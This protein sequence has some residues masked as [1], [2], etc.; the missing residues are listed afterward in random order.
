MD[1]RKICAL[2]ARGQAGW[3]SS[4]PPMHVCHSSIL[5]QNLFPWYHKVYFHMPELQYDSYS[6]TF[7]HYTLGSLNP[8]FP[9]PISEFYTSEP[10]HL[11]Y[12]LSQSLPSKQRSTGVLVSTAR[13]MLKYFNVLLQFTFVM[14]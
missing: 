11:H 2:F 12:N 1:E 14:L 10:K 6:Y 9:I 7:K 4:T 3:L 13:C 5:F 8:A